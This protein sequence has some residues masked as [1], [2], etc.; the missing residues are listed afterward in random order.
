MALAKTGVRMQAGV[1]MSMYTDI[2]DTALQQRS[3][4]AGPP[5]VAEAMSEFLHWRR[6]VESAKRPTEWTAG[7]LANQVACDVALIRLARSVGMECEPGAFEQPDLLRT[8]L[9][10]DLLARG[11]RFDDTALL[12]SKSR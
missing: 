9:R 10:R 11:L 2:L 8:E 5:T 12:A 7:A 4:L 6:H 3:L 1:V